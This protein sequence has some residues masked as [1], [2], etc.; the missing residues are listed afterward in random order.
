MTTATDPLASALQMQAAIHPTGTPTDDE[1]EIINRNHAVGVLGKGDVYVF[2]ME[3]SNDLEDKH[4]TSMDPATT[5]PN[6][7]A[8]FR[9]GRS[10][11]NSHNTDELPLGRSFDAWLE[12]RSDPDRTA[13]VLK[14]YVRCG[15]T[16]GRVSSDDLIRGIDA[17]V[18]KDGSVHFDDRARHVCSIC[19]GDMYERESTCAHLPGFVYG[20][21]RAKALIVDGHAVEASLVFDGSTPKA[22]VD[23]A[24]RMVAAGDLDARQVALVERR[25]RVRFNAP[26]TQED[27]EMN[28]NRTGDGEARALARAIVQRQD[29]ASAVQLALDHMAAGR[30]GH[31]D[32]LDHLN[33]G[34]PGVMLPY[35]RADGSAQSIPLDVV[36]RFIDTALVK[37]QGPRESYENAERTL[38][39]ELALNMGSEGGLKSGLPDK[40]A[41][42][43]DLG[44]GT[45]QL[46]DFHSL[47]L[48]GSVVE[49]AIASGGM[50][51]AKKERRHHLYGE[52]PEVFYARP[53]TRDEGDAA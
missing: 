47:G 21:R 45:S 5:L 20:G 4:H 25:Y 51:R 40:L 48:S 3:V 46:G 27:Y 18:V 50:G 1:L 39:N 22:M 49:G 15:I 53:F 7:V 10:I 28:R 38:Q 29:M 43:E 44:Q 14:G 37:L 11:Q 31:E 41:T 35:G 12:R 13:A 32:L 52:G 36:R 30:A 19:G 8:D 24:A 33:T 34:I 17:G 2:R 26:N 23:K 9:E 6:Y 42:I 16:L